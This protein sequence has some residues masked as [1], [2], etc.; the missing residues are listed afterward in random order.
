ME[1]TL[2]SGTGSLGSGTGFPDFG[3]R[4]NG[5]FGVRRVARVMIERE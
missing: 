5:D 3:V 2:G 1:L 4:P